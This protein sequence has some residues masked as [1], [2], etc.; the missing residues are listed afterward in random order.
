MLPPDLE[1]LAA[2]AVASGRYRDTAE[3][4]RAAL[5]VVRQLD[6][7]RAKFVLSLGAAQRDGEQ[8]GFYSLDDIFAELGGLIAEDDRAEA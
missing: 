3:V 7:T 6:G 5:Q 4:I 8:N 2:E 1:Q